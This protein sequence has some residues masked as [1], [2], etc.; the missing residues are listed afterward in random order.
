DGTVLKVMEH[1]N[2]SAIILNTSWH[3]SGL[4]FVIGD[5]G[6][7]L[8]GENVP[9]L[10]H[11]WSKEGTYIRS[12]SGNKAEIRNLSWNHQGTRLAT[13]SDLLRIWTETGELI[14][15]GIQDSNNKLWG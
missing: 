15:E 8:E 2:P 11:F 5:Y 7:N 14:H 6:Y 13:A 3:P 4:F 1:K 12:V 9:S 10:L